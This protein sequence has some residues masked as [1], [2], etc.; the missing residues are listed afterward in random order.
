[1]SQPARL[2]PFGNALAGAIGGCLSN[3]VV[4]PLDTYVFSSP[5]IPFWIEEN[6]A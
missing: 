3:A 5:C 1:M 4:Y 6:V 2:S